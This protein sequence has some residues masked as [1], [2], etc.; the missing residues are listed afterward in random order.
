[1]A[2]HWHRS[3]RRDSGYSLAE[4]SV[5]LGIIGTLAILATP[6]FV[7]YYQASRLRVAAEEVAAFLNQGRQIGIR[8]NVGVCVHIT[9]T[10]MHYHLGSCAGVTWVGPGTDAAGN[11][12][13]PDGMTLT[14]SADPVFTYLGA[15]APAATYTVTNSQD[16]HTLNVVVAASGRISITG[17]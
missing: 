2:M 1:M 11:V 9:P 13:V 12:K 10:A 14:T 15:A 17:P 6:L 7:S 16:N 8:E 5:V 3:Q 4:L